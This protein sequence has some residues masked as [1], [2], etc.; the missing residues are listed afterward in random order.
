VDTHAIH[1]HLWNAQ[2]INRVDWAGMLKPPDPNEMGWKETIR[3]NPLEN[4]IVAVRPTAPKLPFPIPISERPMDVTSGIGTADP[5][6]NASFPFTASTISN[7]LAFY[8]WEYVWHCHIL[9]H[10]EN[11]MMRPLVMT[12]VTNYLT[13]LVNAPTLNS[14]VASTTTPSVTLTWTDPANKYETGFA[15]QR[16]TANTFSTASL[17]T[18]NVGLTPVTFLNTGVP[19]QTN[20]F[21][22]LAATNNQGGLSTSP[23]SNF[24][25]VG[26]FG[27]PAQVT[28]L[29][30][31][32]SKNKQSL[33][34]T[35]TN[36]GASASGGPGS[37]GAPTSVII[38][39]AIVANGVPG[40]FTTIAT[41]A[42]SPGAKTFTDTN[43]KNVTYAYRIQLTNG[44][45]AGAYS[46]VIQQ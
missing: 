20:F 31:A 33:T 11:D 29:V 26:T 12:N 7:A 35:W 17:T 9:G 13:T 24:L 36:P 4:V 1:F 43:L 28:T 39:R 2:V 15:I 3:M 42:T 46:N 37:F 14:A 19:A 30:G 34:L 22:R 18:F 6:A 41:L 40:P 25:P 10:E 32:R 5:N 23:Y 27:P 38:Q 44:Y 21:Y 8:G 16:D 45:G